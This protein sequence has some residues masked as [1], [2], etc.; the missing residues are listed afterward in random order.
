MRAHASQRSAG[1]CLMHGGLPIGLGA[2]PS[3]ELATK[4]GGAG[5]QVLSPI[6]AAHLLLPFDRG[7]SVSIL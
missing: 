2:E 7:F 3:Y 5:K 1:A 6:P 4:K